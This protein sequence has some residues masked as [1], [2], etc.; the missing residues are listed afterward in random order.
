MNQRRVTMTDIAKTIGVSHVT[1]SLALRNHPRISQAM[2]KQI[3]DKA[4]EMGYQPDP[5]LTILAHYRHGRTESNVQAAIAWI[6][7]WPDPKDLRGFREFDGYWHGASEA[8]QK[9]GYRLEEFVVDKNMPLNRLEKILT[10]RNIKGILLPPHRGTP[11]WKDFNW[12]HFSVVRLGRTVQKPEMHVVTADQTANT[13]LAVRKILAMD[14]QRIAYVGEKV[15]V[16]IF[17]AGFMQVQL[18][19]PQKLRIPPLLLVP[20]APEN[21]RLL[22]KWLKKHKPQVVIADMGDVPKMLRAEGVSIPQDL[23]LVGLSQLDGNISAGIDQHPTEIGRV[24]VLTVISL[25]NDFAQGVPAIFRQ[26]LVEGSWVDGPSLP[27]LPVSK[28]SGGR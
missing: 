3:Q 14:Y 18:E 2:R 11:D 8:A 19:F 26:I 5:M 6:N 25:I 23:G 21:S 17:S 24:A 15:P 10:T 28:L 20:G 16:R 12:N 9:F 4:L 13:M 27:P 1:V 7:C 22:I